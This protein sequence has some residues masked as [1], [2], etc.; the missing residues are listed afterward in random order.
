MVDTVEAQAREDVE[1]TGGDGLGIAAFVTG[2]LG[3][4]PVAIVLGALG[5]S[6]WRRGEATH[7]S[8]PFAGLVLG[9]VG[10]LGWAV[11]GVIA[12]TSGASA[13]ER[14]LHAQAD[15]VTLGNAVVAWYAENPGAAEVE[16]AVDGTSYLV[17]EDAIEMTLPADAEPS[18]A[19]DGVTAYDWCLTLGYA[20][21]ESDAVAY[22]ATQG[23]LD[24]CPEQ[25]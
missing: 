16:V 18:V 3:L 8:W 4:G 10:T 6:R 12:A 21:G 13:A 14:D 15:A 19:V 9:I 2:A 23:L 25:G 7:R 22:G 17:G 5:L 1:P 24:A 11:I 20:G